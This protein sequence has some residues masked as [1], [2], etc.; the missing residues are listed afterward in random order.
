M[1]K[2]GELKAEC[3]ILRLQLVILAKQL[4]ELEEEV[5]VSDVRVIVVVCAA[6]VAGRAE[7]PARDRGRG[8]GAEPTRTGL[9]QTTKMSLK[10]LSGRE[11]SSAS[12]IAVVVVIGVGVVVVFVIL[13]RW[14]SSCSDSCLRDRRRCQ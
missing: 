6:A 14:P 12:I 10:R 7:R 3:T 1:T 9:A 11:A 4:V 5:V 8:P 13:R 2:L